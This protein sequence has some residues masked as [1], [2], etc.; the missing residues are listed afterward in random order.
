MDLDKD[1]FLE[2]DFNLEEIKVNKRHKDATKTEKAILSAEI[3]IEKYSKKLLRRIKEKFLQIYSKFNKFDFITKILVVFGIIFII[4]LS[5]I[6]VLKFAQKINLNKD[7]EKDYSGIDRIRNSFGT[8]E[9]YDKFSV[10]RLISGNFKQFD[11][12]RLKY[13]GNE[14]IIGYLSVFDTSINTPIVQGDDNTYYQ[15]HNIYGDE[16]MNGAVYADIVSDLDDFGKNTVIYGHTDIVEKQLYEIQKYE[17]A[18]FYAQNRYIN[19]DTIYGD[20][21]WEVFS[22][23]KN[24]EEEF[25][26][27]TD[28]KDEEFST[29]I[30]SVKNMSQYEV[31]TNVTTNDKIITITSSN[32]Q[33]DVY[34]LQAKLINKSY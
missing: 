10:D 18:D 12:L 20:S 17:N 1:N 13:N 14:D 27:K 6:I 2:D 29:Y 3:N 11:N 8:I 32:E 9:T 7:I 19:L 34:V 31:D 30:A 15:D 28:F 26:L 25:Y 22:F 33:G 24:S 23:Y 4:F 5:N 16:D 21:V